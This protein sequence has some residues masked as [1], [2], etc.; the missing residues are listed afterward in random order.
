MKSELKA[1]AIMHYIHWLSHLDYHRSEYSVA[2]DE[3]TYSLLD[4]LFDLIKQIQPSSENGV[5]SFWLCSDRGTIED[6]GDYEEMY[7]NNEVS[8]YEEFESLWKYEFPEEKEW[9][10]FQALDDPQ[11]GYRCIVMNHHLIIETDLR[12]EKDSFPYNISEFVSWLVNAVQSLIEELK[13][14]IYN[15]RVRRELPIQHRTGTILRKHF[16]DVYPQ[17]REEF[18][19]SISKEDVAEFVTYM[20]DQNRDSIKGLAHMT[21]GDFYR[22]CALGY[23]ENHY[24]GCDLSPKEQYYKH[25]DGRDGGLS[26]I[27]MDSPDDFYKWYCDVAHTG[28]HPWEV[29]RGGNSTHVSLYLHYREGSWNLIVAGD[30]WNRTIESVKFY[31]ALRREGL[32][33]YME[34]GD[35][36]ADRLMETEKIGI[37]PEGVFPAYCS[38]FFPEETI[39]DYMNL[40][41]EN[42]D[43]LAPFCRWQEIPLVKLVSEI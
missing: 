18:F 42:R 43:R 26:E 11:I 9:F 39:I 31:L 19:S 37:V 27:D 4:D 41:F 10:L 24:D 28:A 38:G 6:F 30:A 21:S 5:R 23:A 13:H 36:L 40:P 12:K 14:N 29:C 22:F 35:L 1:P 15:D 8:N 7:E 17:A 16:W 25:A 32:P 2:Y 3:K 20:K 33:V 34:K